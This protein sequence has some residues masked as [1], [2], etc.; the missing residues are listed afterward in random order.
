LAAGTLLSSKILL[1]SWLHA[2]GE[3]IQLR[4]LMDNRQ[5]LAP[6]VNLGMIGKTVSQDS[7]QYHLLGMGI[8]SEDPRE[9]VHGQITTLKT[10]MMHPIIQKLPFDLRT[11]TFVTR[12]LRCALGV[13]NVNFRDTR[14]DDNYVALSDTKNGDRS[15]LV[16]HYAPSADEPTRMRDAMGKVKRTLRALGCVMPPGMAHMRPMGASVHYAGT[17]PMSRNSGSLTTTE[18]CQSRDFDNLF[19]VDGSTFP[20]LPAKNLTFTLMANAVRIA[21]AAF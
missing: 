19:L 15:K 21:E 7:Y 10:A 14:R 4:G 3:S 2:T 17:L 9:Y 18:Y 12:A 11:S 8:Q 16:I 20:F 13:V 5:I 1:Q 6:F